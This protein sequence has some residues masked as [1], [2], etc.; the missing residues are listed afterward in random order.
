MKS[1]NIFLSAIFF[2]VIYIMTS[3]VNEL[4][5]YDEPNGGISG[6]I[7]D[8]ETGEAVP[9]PVQGSTGVIIKMME[10]NTEA[11][12]SVD[13]YALQDGTFK[14]TRVFNCE[15]LI[16]VD[17]PFVEPGEVLTTVN[18]Q[19][20]V[21]IPVTPYARI[22]AEAQSE[23]KKVSIKYHVEKTK[24]SFITSEIY[25]YWNFAPGVDDGGA[26]QA[27]KITVNELDGTIVFD[28]ENDQVFKDNEYKIKD[29][30]NKVYVRIGAK[31]EG[32]INYSQVITVVLN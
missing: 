5:N 3:C 30:G 2:S 28:L 31:T 24:E 26:N 23:G 14:N 6:T 18:G 9:L 13:F 17:G 19:T 29:N 21:D 7:V 11:T 15:Y 12:K 20:K 27:G 4:D 16:T 25:G 22:S 32:S 1:I 10:Q 8:A